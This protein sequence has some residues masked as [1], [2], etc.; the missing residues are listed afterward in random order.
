MKI[1]KNIDYKKFIN[2]KNKKERKINM[3][4]INNEI[5]E[6]NNNVKIENDLEKEQNNF[7]N[8]FLGKAINTAI[9]FGIRAILPDF[10]EEQIINVKN[11]LIDN[12]LKEGIQKT[13]DDVINLG[14]S[15]IGL[16]TGKIEN[17]EQMQDIVK[18]GGVIDGVS[19]LWDFVV[20]KVRDS[21]KLKSDVATI[22]KNGKDVVLNNVEKNIENSFKKE[23]TKETTLEENINK[24]KEAYEKQDFNNME[25]V[26]KKIE[27]EMKEIAPLEKIINNARVV[28]NLHTLIKNNGQNFNLSQEQI[29]LAKK[30]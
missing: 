19:E 28:E 30:L 20:D 10:L 9:D 14:K 2:Y 21:G 16:V 23:I 4:K 24:W 11:N 26:Y 13:I 12:G 1:T 18:S 8:S 7:F 22:L 29:E 27:K 17:V 5:L 15:T 6:I 25:K 3:E